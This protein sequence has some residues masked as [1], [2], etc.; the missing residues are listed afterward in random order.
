MKKYHHHHAFVRISWEIIRN[1][2]ALEDSIKNQISKCTTLRE[3]I[4]LES[5]KF[6]LRCFNLLNNITTTY[7]LRSLLKVFLSTNSIW[8]ILINLL[9]KLQFSN[10]TTQTEIIFNKKILPKI[11][12]QLLEENKLLIMGKFLYQLMKSL[13]E[14]TN[15]NK[16]K[17]PS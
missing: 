9:Q 8:I 5:L 11:A 4:N 10:L 3:I 7:Q 12:I 2:M 14:M 6:T 13:Q 1:K 17:N 16:R 15:I